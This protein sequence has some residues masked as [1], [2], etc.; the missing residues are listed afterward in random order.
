[1]WGHISH[2]FGSGGSM[3]CLSGRVTSY[4][5]DI[6]NDVFVCRI[7]SSIN[8]TDTNILSCNILRMEFI[9]T[10]RANTLTF[11]TMGC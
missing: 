1:M 7:K 3:G 2:N 9:R 8:N 6:I 4:F 5:F 10:H 11:S